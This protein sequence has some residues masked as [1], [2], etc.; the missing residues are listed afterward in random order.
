MVEHIH[1]ETK[2]RPEASRDCSW[3][4]CLS[5]MCR[6]PKGRQECCCN[7][8]K[9]EHCPPSWCPLPAAAQATTREELVALLRECNE[10]EPISPSM[11]YRIDAALKRES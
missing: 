7:Y 6:H 10:A 5:E 9:A 11:H 8:L 1:A 3:R 4:T 2:V